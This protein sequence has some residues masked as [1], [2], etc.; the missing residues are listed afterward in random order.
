MSQVIN[1]NKTEYSNETQASYTASARFHPGKDVKAFFSFLIMW[2]CSSGCSVVK[3]LGYWLEVWE[4]KLP[5][6]GQWGRSLILNCLGLFCLKSLC[7]IVSVHWGWC[8][9]RGAPSAVKWT[10]PKLQN[11]LLTILAQASQKHNICCIFYNFFS[12]IF[13]KN[14]CTLALNK[15]IEWGESLYDT[16]I[17]VLMLWVNII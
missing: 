7:K 11:K 5:L 10:T 6:P 13:N 3:V 15:D 14:V 8:K 9:F 2:Q 17:C 1:H 12:S 16:Y 4:F